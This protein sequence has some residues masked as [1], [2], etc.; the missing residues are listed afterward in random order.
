MPFGRM[1]WAGIPVVLVVGGITYLTAGKRP[2]KDR[3][4][5][6][7]DVPRVV[8]PVAVRV[9][10][11]PP[12]PLKGSFVALTGI[13][14]DE[15][16]SQGFAVARPMEVRVYAVGEGMGGDM[17]DYGWIVNA[18][19]RQTVWR[20]DYEHS[21]HAGGAEKNRMIDEVITLDAG[22]YMVYYAS[23]G[24]HSWSDWNSRAPT[25]QEAWGI[26][27]L[28]PSGVVDREA[29]REYEVAS[30][31]SVLA[32]LIGMRDDE[33]RGYKFVLTE[34]TKVGIYALG[35]GSDGEMYD[36]AWIQDA[37]TGRAVWEMTYG[38][39][40]HAGGGDK[41]RLYKGSIILPAGDYVLRYRSDGSHSL[42]EWNVNPPENPF[43]YGVTLTREEG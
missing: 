19:T 38:M 7:V 15:L 30:D 11:T 28:S 21:E 29:V 1:F 27:L 6:V 4:V 39:T 16:V 26:T 25:H 31:P 14:D 12:P 5:H 37:K 8:A 18:D 33:N 2:H 10:P 20:M 13:G 3:V 17:Y 42:E 9:K 23:D 32:Q 40:E 34:E 22:N 41:N 36:F 24:S 35:E 43:D